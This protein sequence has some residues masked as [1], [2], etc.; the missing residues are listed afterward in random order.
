MQ[1]LSLGKAA[2]ISAGQLDIS[3]RR[4]GIQV[5]E[6]YEFELIQAP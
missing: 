3:S 2:I 4:S 5:S 1:L 6:D